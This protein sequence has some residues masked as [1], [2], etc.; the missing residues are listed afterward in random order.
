MI[1]AEV[2]YTGQGIC[3]GFH[4]ACPAWKVL[5]GHP[6]VP[7]LLLP[8]H[9]LHS[10]SDVGSPVKRAACTHHA[11]IVDPAPHF[12][13]LCFLLCSKGCY[14]LPLPMG[15]DWLWLISAEPAVQITASCW[16]TTAPAAHPTFSRSQGTPCP[17]SP[18]PALGHHLTPPERIQPRQLR[19]MP[20]ASGTRTHGT[21][22]D[23]PYSEEHPHPGEL[24]W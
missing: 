22:G 8:W 24:S 18:E 6:F 20:S 5:R 16:D 19:V 7:A 4:F 14:C 1:R 23:V 21:T 3:S 13:E 12:L 9:L 17:P 2:V 11:G 10:W 15:W